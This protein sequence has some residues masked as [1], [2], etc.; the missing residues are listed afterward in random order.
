MSQPQRLYLMQVADVPDRNIPIVCYLVQTDDGRNILIDTGLPDVFTP[1]PGLNPEMGA[2]VVEQLASIG[3]QPAD[4]DTLICTHFDTDHSG[5]HSAF[6]N[7]ELI[8][9]RDQYALGQTSPRFAQNRAEWN[10]PDARLRLIESDLE[11]LPGLQILRTDGHTLGHQSVMVCLPEN[12]PILL[13]IDAVPNQGL[14]TPDRPATPADEDPVAVQASAQKLLDVV[15]REG[16]TLTVFGHDGDQWQQL[17]KLP[18]YY[19]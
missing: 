14:F 4:V 8:I 9:Q 13:A 19:S 5:R 18:E 10:R 2:H 7:A 16:I 1:P 12:G 11:L 17:K 6:P 3:V 15:S